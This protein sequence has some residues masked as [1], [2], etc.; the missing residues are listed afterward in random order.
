MKTITVIGI[1]AVLLLAVI[2]GCNGQDE[3]DKG[4]L[5]VTVL[6]E[7]TLPLVGVKVVSETQ[8]EG[9]LKV[10]GITTDNGTVIFSDILTGAYKFYVSAAGFLQMEFETS[11]M[12]GQTA[13]TTV[14]MAPTP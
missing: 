5:E 2:T 8:P 1:L 11:I 4:S 7:G 14:Y 12:A 9:Q 13:E 6:A 10:T 3:P